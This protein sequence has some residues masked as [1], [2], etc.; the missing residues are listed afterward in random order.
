MGGAPSVTRIDNSSAWLDLF[1]ACR[2]G[3]ADAVRAQ[4]HTAARGAHVVDDT[5]ATALMWAAAGG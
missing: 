2:S 3:D 1:R 4:L 5:G